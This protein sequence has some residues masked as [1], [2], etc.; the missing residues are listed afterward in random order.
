MDIEVLMVPEELEKNELL[1]LLWEDLVNP[2]LKNLERAKATVE[3][4]K[5]PTEEDIEELIESSEVQSIIETREALEAAEKEAETLRVQLDTW[6]RETLSVS[7]SADEK[8]TAQQVLNTEK[9]KLKDNLSSMLA[10]AEQ[11]KLTEAIEFI[12]NVQSLV[13]PAPVSRSSKTNLMEMRTWLK[14]RG[15]EV[16]DRGRIPLDLQKIYN[17]AQG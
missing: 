2:G 3:S 16:S 12:E 17:A 11:Y 9:R 4:L 14:E 6:A 10:Q 8:A 5:P 1:R 13:S 15:H 7:V